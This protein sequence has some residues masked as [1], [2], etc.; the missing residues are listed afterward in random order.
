VSVYKFT[1]PQDCSP[2]ILSFNLDFLSLFKRPG[3]QGSANH[4]P[5]SC[6]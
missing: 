4:M 2:L 5:A 6:T 3:A 1:D